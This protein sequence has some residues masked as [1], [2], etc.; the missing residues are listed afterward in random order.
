VQSDVDSCVIWAN[1]AD[2][3]CSACRIFSYYNKANAPHEAWLDESCGL[4]LLRDEAQKLGLT[5]YT[6]MSGT[7]SATCARMSKPGATA[8]RHLQLIFD[9]D[10]FNQSGENVW[11]NWSDYAI[12]PTPSTQRL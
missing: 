11:A 2:F 10:N 4:T 12:E 3:E 8:Q 6:R 7:S 1:C 5:L 9:F